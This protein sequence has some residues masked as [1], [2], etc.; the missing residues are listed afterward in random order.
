MLGIRLWRRVL[1]WRF[2]E[3]LG[4]V[5]DRGRGERRRPATR[6]PVPLDAHSTRT[7]LLRIAAIFGLPSHVGPSRVR[8]SWRSAAGMF[9]QGGFWLRDRSCQAPCD[10]YNVEGVQNKFCFPTKTGDKIAGPTVLH[11][12]GGA[13]G[14]AGDFAGEGADFFGDFEDRFVERLV[15]LH[16]VGRE[17]SLLA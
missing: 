2:L 8:S 5:E 17:E 9:F 14:G 3:V 10:K 6:S 13:G 11:V 12:G 16:F 1:I 15:E 7:G 4:R